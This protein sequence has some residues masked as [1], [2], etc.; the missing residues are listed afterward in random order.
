MKRLAL[1]TILIIGAVPMAALAGGPVPWGGAGP[2]EFDGPPDLLQLAATEGS[3]AEH[4]K[5]AIIRYLDLSDAQIEAWDALIEET[6]AFAEPL[7][8]RVQ[9]I[10]D[11]LAALFESDD[12]DAESVGG[13]VIERH[14]LLEELFRLHREYVDRFEHG[15][16]T[17]DQH[18]KYH[19]VRAAARVQPLIPAFRLFALIPPRR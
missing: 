7:R 12:T 11:E 15:I 10:D 8:N 19:V 4:A 13:L 3:I 14:G 17:V 9:E 2:V 6:S 1:A 16:L 18:R 5:S